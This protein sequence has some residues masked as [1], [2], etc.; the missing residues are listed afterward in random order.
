LQKMASGTNFV[1]AAN[2]VCSR[3]IRE[4]IART[5]PEARIFPR[6]SGGRASFTLTRLRA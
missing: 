1:R 3:S 2:S 5:I 6:S 4:Y